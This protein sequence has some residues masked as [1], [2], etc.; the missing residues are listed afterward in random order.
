MTKPK[1][2]GVFIKT[3]MKDLPKNC[4]KCRFYTKVDELR[5]CW[6]NHG[7]RPQAVK[8]SIIPPF[9]EVSNRRWGKCPLVHGRDFA[10][11][12]HYKAGI[13]D[14]NRGYNWRHATR[15]EIEKVEKQLV[16][17]GKVRKRVSRND[18]VRYMGHD[19]RADEA[20]RTG[21]TPRG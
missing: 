7:Y 18:G 11:M 20:K 17:Q 6:A 5:F 14:E 13:S 3:R 9:V 16:K 1:E 8:T 15:K 12:E 19:K 2:F 4:Y 21:A 10:Y